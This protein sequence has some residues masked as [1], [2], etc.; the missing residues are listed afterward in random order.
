MQ[1]RKDTSA[2]L[3]WKRRP[4]DENGHHR[5]PP[6]RTPPPERALRR[7]AAR[8]LHAPDRV[9]HALDLHV[10]HHL[11]LGVAELGREHDRGAAQLD[12][13]RLHRVLHQEAALAGEHA[14]GQ[15]VGLAGAL[16]VHLD[17]AA[18]RLDGDGDGA[19]GVGG[20]GGDDG[21]LL[22]WIGLGRIGL[23]RCDGCRVR[24]V[25]AKRLEEEHARSDNRCVYDQWDCDGSAPALQLATAQPRTHLEVGHVDLHEGED[26]RAEV[27]HLEGAACDGGQLR[28]GQRGREALDVGAHAWEEGG[29]VFR[30]C[31]GRVGSRQEWGGVGWGG[32]GRGVGGRGEQMLA[33]PAAWGCESMVLAPLPAVLV[34]E[35]L[36]AGPLY[37]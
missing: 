9:E 7:H 11:A 22:D 13:A 18:D 35:E 29:V 30:G 31:V 14:A 5:W 23:D 17:E 27:A 24:L 25:L 4:A 2:V 15:V 3:L 21:G 34:E 16:G 12:A 33:T 37:L 10:E 8:L 32:V 6:A 19:L 26:P 1:E 28:A 20:A 36:Q